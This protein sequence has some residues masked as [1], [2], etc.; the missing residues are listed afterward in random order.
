MKL[1]APRNEW[2]MSAPG[3]GWFGEMGGTQTASGVRV[4]ESTAELFSTVVTCTR[5]LSE[6]LASLPCNLLQQIDYRTTKRATDQTL[7]KVVHDQPTPE[8]DI[9]SWM[10]SQVAFQVNWGNAYA[11]IQRNTLGEI[12]ALWPIHPSRI[13]LRNIVRNGTTP[14]AYDGIVAGK[15]GE[16]VYYVNNDDGTKTAIPASDMLH[17]PGV[18]SANGVTGQSVIR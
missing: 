13:P 12:I 8:Q 7:W 16:I 1:F 9:M 11:E 14:D 3:G 5:V 15:P 2:N 18:L 10:D 4:D 17:V 6:T